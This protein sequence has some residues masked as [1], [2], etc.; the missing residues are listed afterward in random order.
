MKFLS[1]LFWEF[2]QNL[3]LIA[4]FIAAF[5]LWQQGRLAIAIVCMVASSSAGALVIRVT[6]SKIF[7]GNRESVR[8]SIT[9][10]V[11][12]TVL[13]LALAAYLAAGWSS[14]WTDI[15]AGLIGAIVL[16]AVQGRVPQERLNVF[17]GL[18]LGLSG[19]VSLILVR[20]LIKT[21]ALTSI[22][23][24]TAW[25]TL[26]M[27]AYKQLRLKAKRDMRYSQ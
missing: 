7:A 10:I 12:F 17:R 15:A 9:N 1:L 2:L 25:F 11:I 24:A 23:A 4:G 14:W 16:A 8:G 22:V 26:V 18:T 19:S 3:P 6:E 27:G 13:M 21:S 20:S 5:Q